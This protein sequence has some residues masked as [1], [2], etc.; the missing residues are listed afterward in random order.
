MI[1]VFKTNVSSKKHAGF[2]LGVLH[3]LFP[4]AHF[5]F[6]LEDRDNILRM[7]AGGSPIRVDEIIFAVREHNFQIEVL[8]DL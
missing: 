7:E 4:G 6:D 8:P 5:N 1:E 2:L 3:G